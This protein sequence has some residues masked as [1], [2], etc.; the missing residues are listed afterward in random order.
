[1]ELPIYM[2]YPKHIPTFDLDIEGLKAPQLAQK[3]VDRGVA[4]GA[5]HL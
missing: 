1:M 4:C 3:L 2:T 5:G